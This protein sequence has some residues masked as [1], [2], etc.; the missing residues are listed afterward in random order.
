VSSCGTYLCTCNRSNNVIANL[1]NGEW[2]VEDLAAYK[3]NKS[4]Q[5]LEVQ[6]C[7]EKAMS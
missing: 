6:V 5:R 1:G 7:V 4:K 3:W 2:T